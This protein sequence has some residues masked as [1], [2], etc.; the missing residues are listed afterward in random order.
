M[1]QLL[2][3]AGAATKPGLRHPRRRSRQV[4]EWVERHPDADT[5]EREFSVAVEYAWNR[6]AQT[7]YF[8]TI[9]VT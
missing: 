2:E 6:Q 4:L 3:L 9:V 8:V 1:T 7:L 5:V